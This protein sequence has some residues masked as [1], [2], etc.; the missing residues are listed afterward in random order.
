M[1]HGSLIYKNN[2][3]N[4]LIFDW[5]FF[6]LLYKFIKKLNNNPLEM[7]FLYHLKMRCK[8]RKYTKYFNQI[9]SNKKREKKCKNLH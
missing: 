1:K 5:V 4:S 6:F 7:C 8:T 3:F 2:A 9:K